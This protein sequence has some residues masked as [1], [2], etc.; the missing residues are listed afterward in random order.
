MPMG[1]FVLADEVGIDVCYKVAK[2]LHDAY[3]DRIKLSELLRSVYQDKK[4]L[5]KKAGKG[6]YLHDGKRDVNPELEPQTDNSK[7]SD[8]EIT[9]RCILLMVNEAAMILQENM[10]EKPEFLDMAMIMG[11]GFPAFRGG[12]CRYADAYG[13]ANVVSRLTELETAH[14]KRFTPAQLLV[15]MAKENKK[16]YS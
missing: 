6:F 14:G 3:G 13:I 5:G 10:I 1:P 11:T 16:F 7:I 12:L 2:I 8:K 4:L 9:D 15:N